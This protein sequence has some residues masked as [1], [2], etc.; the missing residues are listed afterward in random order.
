MLAQRKD[1]NFAN[2]API[3]R[4]IE[5][6]LSANIQA[7]ESLKLSRKQQQ[8]TG[9]KN[10]QDNWL[11]KVMIRIRITLSET[12]SWTY[13]HQ[14]GSEWTIIKQWTLLSHYSFIVLSGQNAFHATLL[15]ERHKKA[16]FFCLAIKS[17][18]PALAVGISQVTR[19]SRRFRCP[20]M[21]NRKKREEKAGNQTASF[22]LRANCLLDHWWGISQTTGRWPTGQ[23]EIVS[24]RS[25][26]SRYYWA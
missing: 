3:R 22:R 17:H 25:C 12:Y 2:Q 15:P 7:S 24:S 10:K 11:S 4:L 8:M 5:W 21:R 23:P 1:S 18:Q 26:Y 13:E 20:N 14:P 9:K 19:K 16:E 6:P